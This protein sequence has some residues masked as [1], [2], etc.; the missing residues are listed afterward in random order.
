MQA[1]DFS[2]LAISVVT[3]L[4]VLQTGRLTQV[5]T[6]RKVL[7]CSSIWLMPL[8]TSTT[9]TAMGAM[10]PVS[11]NWCW[12]KKERTDLRYGLTHGWRMAIIFTTVGIYTYVWIHVSR[13]FR[14]LGAITG[15]CR[16]HSS[17]NGPRSAQEEDTMHIADPGVVYNP[18]SQELLPKNAVVLTRY[19]SV[20]QISCQPTATPTPTSPTA[21]PATPGRPLDLEQ[22]AA[23]TFLQER[24][25]RQAWEVKKMLLMNGYP[26]FY[27]FLWIPGLVNRIME[28]SGIKTTNRILAI[29][30][31]STQFIGF[32]NA[33]TYGLTGIWKAGK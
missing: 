24:A 15:S 1:T 25:R 18:S 11:G 21:A 16:S 8:I 26:I 19:S 12:I 4:V 32:A 27:V 14:S 9:A 33:V 17:A 2:I 6:L 7:I 22:N 10:G 20:D 28:A 13:H 3:L 29:L 31:T 23:T 30:Q 5:S